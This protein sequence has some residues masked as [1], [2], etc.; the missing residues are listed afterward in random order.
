MVRQ[1][2]FL[3]EA[4]L[5]R[6]VERY[7]SGAK[8]KDLAVEFD[9]NRATVSDHLSRRGVPRRPYPPTADAVDEMVRLYALD[10]P[11]AAVGKHV[12]YSPFVVQRHLRERGVAIRPKTRRPKRERPSPS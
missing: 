2:K 12:G 8:V 1:S 9:I 5:T 3:T 4:E 10:L 11:L 6:L 7:E